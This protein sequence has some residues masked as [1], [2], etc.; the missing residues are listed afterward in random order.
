[1]GFTDANVPH[2]MREVFQR[3]EV[4]LT[5][6]DYS[7]PDC[8]LIGMNA[9]FEQLSGYSADAALGRNCRFLQPSGGIGPVRT[10]MRRFLAPGGGMNAKFVVPNLTRSGEPFLNLIYLAKLTI[11]GEVGLVLGSQFGFSGKRALPPDL[12]DRA[13][14]KDLR[15]F[16]ELTNEHNWGVLTSFDA[17]ASSHSIIAQSRLP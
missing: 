9:A 1:M 11:D 4:S 10:R 6:A 3:S 8:P 5:L 17:L 12:Y 7:A 16:D 14:R 15:R 13:L 2:G